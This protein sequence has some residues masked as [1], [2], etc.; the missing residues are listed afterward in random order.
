[1]TQISVFDSDTK[2]RVYCEKIYK[3]QAEWVIQTLKRI[4]EKPGRLVSGVKIR[5]GWTVFTLQ[6]VEEEF[7][8][9]EPDFLTNPFEGL[10]RDITT[11]LSVLTQQRDFIK[12]IRI[13]PRETAFQDKVVLAKGCL[14]ETKIYLERSTTITEMDSGWFIGYVDDETD[15][16]KNLE[17]IYVYELLKYRASLLKVLN[18]PANYLVV[19]DEDKIEVVLDENDEGI[20]SEIVN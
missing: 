10:S 7:I 20:Y 19:F 15:K 5:F 6:L 1:M 11:S 16:N 4:L 2:L 9:C 14:S 18:L 13:E 8:V 3:P 12:Q 17:A